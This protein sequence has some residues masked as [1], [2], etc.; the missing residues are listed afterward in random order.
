[1]RGPTC[2][3]DRC[4]GLF[5]TSILRRPTPMAPDETMMTLW[6]SFLSFT[7][8]STMDVRMER[9]GSWLFSSTMEL[10]PGGCVS[11]VQGLGSVVLCWVSLTELDHDAKGTRT[12]HGCTMKADSSQCVSQAETGRGVRSQ[13][14][15]ARCIISFLRDFSLTQIP[16]RFHYIASGPRLLAGCCSGVL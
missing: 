10:V 5:S 2:S 11:N 6:P 12:P 3:L 1:M 8:V 13:E 4:F 14:Q 16:T 15:G 9:S 7:A